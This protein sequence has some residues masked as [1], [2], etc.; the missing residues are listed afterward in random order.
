MSRGLK[1]ALA[2]VV[3]GALAATAAWFGL[4]YRQRLQ[5]QRTISEYDVA[6]AAALYDLKP[7]AMRP[8]TADREFTRVSNYISSLWGRDVFME[9]ELLELELESVR[10]EDPT[11]TVLAREKWRYVERDKQTGKQLHAPTEEEQL[12]TYTLV[13]EDDGFVVYLSE[14][15]ESP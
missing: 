12:L 8:H 15:R 13:P 7:E 6:L 9:A 14:L 11:V 10:S 1:I 2:L 4:R 3:V 5:V